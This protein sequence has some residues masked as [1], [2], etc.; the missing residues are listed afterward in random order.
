M[1]KTVEIKVDNK[2]F[3]LMFN[4]QKLM[5]LEKRIGQSITYL[6][7]KG[8]DYLVKS[9]DIGFTNYSL[10]IG[11]N[12]SEDEA[13]N[14]IDEYCNEGGTIDLLNGKI[15]ESILA[16]GLF[17]MGTVKTQEK[18]EAVPAKKTKAKK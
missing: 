17:T 14:L 18:Q 12:I 1:K 8:S 7:S 11:L 3:E 13:F 16:T 15:M 2:T 4:I 10:Q 9:L 6:F 5:I